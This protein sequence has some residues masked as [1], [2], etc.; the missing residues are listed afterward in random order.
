MESSPQST[1]PPQEAQATRDDFDELYQEFTAKYAYFGNADDFRNGISQAYTLFR[2]PDMRKK[3][4]SETLYRFVF[5]QG[6][7]AKMV[8]SSVAGRRG[9]PGDFLKWLESAPDL[10]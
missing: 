10:G 3:A 7:F 4:I 2:R 6:Q 8:E 9:D 1:T 5:Y